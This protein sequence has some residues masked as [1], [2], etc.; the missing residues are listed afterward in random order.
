MEI[1]DYDPMIAPAGPAWLELA[2]YERFEAAV[3]AHRR[4]GVRLPN[5]RIHAAAHVVVENQVAL[6]DATPVAAALARLTAEGLER[7][8]AVHAI[9][10]VVMA[11]VRE[12]MASGVPIGD[13]PD[14]AYA[15]RLG[16]VTAAS[17]RARRGDA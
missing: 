4:L 7:H 11:H 2:E 8:E 13:A 14:V 17:W 5:E 12:L 15:E 3:A 1:G 10:T 16:R 9:G 6:G